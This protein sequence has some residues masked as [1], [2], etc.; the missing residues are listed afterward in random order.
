MKEHLTTFS[1]IH[2]TFNR[3][4]QENL[5]ELHYKNACKQA[6]EHYNH[7]YNIYSK[8]D[9]E[10]LINQYNEILKYPHAFGLVSKVIRMILNERGY[11]VCEWC[12]E[13]YEMSELE[14]CKVGKIC[15][16]CKRGLE[17]RT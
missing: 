11:D 16:H 1:A 3:Q 4:A 17:S 15:K 8:K 12:Q 9:T 7:I 10:T 13:F 6:D 2:G 5:K 14:P